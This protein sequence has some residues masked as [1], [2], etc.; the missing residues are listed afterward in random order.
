M[1]IAKLATAAGVSPQ[2]VYSSVG[3]KVDVVKAVYD[4]RLAGDD[5]SAAMNDRPEIQAVRQAKTAV[6]CLRRYVEVVRLLH[7]R[8]GPLVSALPSGDPT[9]AQFLATI[10]TERRIGNSVVVGHLDRTFGLA[11][12]LDQTRAVDIVWTLTS[13]LTADLLI[14]RCGW[15]V[16]NYAEWLA[17]TL[18]TASSTPLTAERWPRSAGQGKPGVDHGVGVE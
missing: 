8:L 9:L 10:D 5:G 11:P 15:S 2:T 16:N 1:T 3:G 14:R 4:V 6:E 12:D 18:C 13:P 17:D 7:G